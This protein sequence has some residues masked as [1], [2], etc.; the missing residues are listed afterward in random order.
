MRINDIYTQ[1]PQLES[2]KDSKRMNYR[3]YETWRGGGGG[4]GGQ[5]KINTI[6][7]EFPIKFIYLN[8]RPSNLRYL[9]SYLI[10]VQETCVPK[11][12]NSLRIRP[13]RQQRTKTFRHLETP[14]R[15][16]KN[17]PPPPIHQESRENEIPKPTHTHTHRTK[18]YTKG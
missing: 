16:L 6:N 2:Y 12:T 5:M 18:L 9:R 1:K 7:F 3:I 14:S 4:G 13:E 10:S 15:A 11:S 17:P 8:G